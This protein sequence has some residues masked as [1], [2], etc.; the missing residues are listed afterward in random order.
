LSR[1]AKILTQ[2]HKLCLDK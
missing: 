1:H 2:I